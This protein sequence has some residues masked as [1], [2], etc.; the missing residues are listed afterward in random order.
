VTIELTEK[1]RKLADA[2][3]KIKEILKKEELRLK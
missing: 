3:F 1:G 2:L